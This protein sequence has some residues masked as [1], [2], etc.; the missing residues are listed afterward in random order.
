[1]MG[2]SCYFSLGEKVFEP[3]ETDPKLCLKM[4][5]EILA[6]NPGF[7]ILP[8]VLNR[9]LSIPC[10]WESLDISTSYS[11]TLRSVTLKRDTV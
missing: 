1:M 10:G 9:A 7:S 5:W 8:G 2:N 11:T 6:K 4:P 3:G